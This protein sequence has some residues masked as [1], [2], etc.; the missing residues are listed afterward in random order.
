MLKPLVRSL[1]SA[2]V[3][4]SFAL[5]AMAYGTMPLCPT[6]HAGEAETVHAA[7]HHHPQPTHSHESGKPPSQGCAV[8]LCCI[9]LALQ[10]RPSLGPVQLS[11]GSVHSGLAPA[12]SI[13]P[14]RPAHSLPFAHAPPSPLV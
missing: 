7:A 2:V 9:H 12:G 14:E 13:T 8:H 6:Q 10:P 1:L 5:S 11:S 4:A 3:T